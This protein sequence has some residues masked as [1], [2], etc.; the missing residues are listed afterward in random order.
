[1]TQHR[2]L[3]PLSATL[4]FAGA[5][6]L[7]ATAVTRTGRRKSVNHRRDDAPVSAS[8]VST[9][10]DGVVVAA[11]VTIDRPREELYAYWRRFENLPSFMENVEAVVPEGDH[12]RWTISAPAGQTVDLVTKIT[13]DRESELIA[14][15][16][17]LDSEIETNGRVQF[18]SLAEGRGTAV[19]ATIRYVP[20]AGEIGRLVAKLFR[21][22][23]KVQ[24]RHE[25]KRFKMLMETGE[26]TTAQFHT[27]QNGS[28]GD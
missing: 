26:V 9:P 2:P 21:K 27:P 19:E 25:L 5:A 12:M 11:A 17:V 14:W 10:E 13:E 22:E 18:R 20:P 4:L 23:P 7:V 6:F 15:R 24:G 1:M 28:T 8:R 3:H 16:S